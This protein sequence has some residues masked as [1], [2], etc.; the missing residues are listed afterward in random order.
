MA[1]KDVR[2]REPYRRRRSARGAIPRAATQGR[3]IVPGLRII[4]T[5]LAATGQ[6]CRPGRHRAGKRETMGIARRPVNSP[7]RLIA[8]RNECRCYY[9]PRDGSGSVRNKSACY[10][11]SPRSLADEP[12]RR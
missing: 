3:L 12:R 10:E 2:R 7:E 4:A 1:E 5:L 6:P 9:G 8:Y 11:A